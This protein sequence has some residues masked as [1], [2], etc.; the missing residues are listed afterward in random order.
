MDDQDNELEALESI[1]ID[2]SLEPIMLSFAFL[3][4]IT[5]NF[6][7]VIG[8]GGFGLVYMVRIFFQIALNMSNFK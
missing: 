3:K 5:K 6:S 7:Q 2:S 8:S 4:H 1:L